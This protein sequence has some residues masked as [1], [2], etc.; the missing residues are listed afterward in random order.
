MW[1]SE[2]GM[3]VGTSHTHYIVPLSHFCHFGRKSISSD[4]CE[5]EVSRWSA[6]RSTMLY[7]GFIPV[8]LNSDVLETPTCT[9]VAGGSTV[10]VTV[11]KTAD[12][13]LAAKGT[14]SEKVLLH[15]PKPSHTRTTGHSI[16][17]L[18]SEACEHSAKKYYYTG[19]RLHAHHG[20]WWPSMIVETMLS[21]PLCPPE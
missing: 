18:G 1:S 8:K 20:S 7:R 2:A 14:R 5:A 3:W 13:L 17:V 9:W 15:R 21:T 11:A 19:E 6:D 4:E 16:L 12:P 10:T